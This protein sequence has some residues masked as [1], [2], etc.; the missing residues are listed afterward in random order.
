[1]Y[2]LKHHPGRR[3]VQE[4]RRY[5]ISSEFRMLCQCSGHNGGFM[6]KWCKP[7]SCVVMIWVSDKSAKSL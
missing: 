4:N 7:V 1:M 6:G 5:G 3:K 2:I